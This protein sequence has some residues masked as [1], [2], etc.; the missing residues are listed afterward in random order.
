MT[1]DIALFIKDIAENI[2]N[3]ESF[4]ANLTHKQFIADRKTSYALVRCLEIIGEA[5]K[6]VPEGIRRKYP[7]VPWKKMAG[8]RDKIIHFY[9][10]V[11]YKIVWNT[12]KKDIPMLKP[13][14]QKVLDD[15]EANK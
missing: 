15:L 7:E 1:R 12:V 13:L 2:E 8:M 4:A 14:V 11:K 3:A 9:F 6:N 10:G 5:S